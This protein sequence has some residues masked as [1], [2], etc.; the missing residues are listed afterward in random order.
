V[1]VED[2]LDRGVGGISPVGDF[3]ELDELPTATTILN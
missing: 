1:I 2:D 3:E